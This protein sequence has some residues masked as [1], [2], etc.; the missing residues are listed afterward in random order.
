MASESAVF[1]YYH[2][3]HL[4]LPREA[5]NITCKWWVILVLL[6]QFSYFFYALW[7]TE[8]MVFVDAEINGLIVSIS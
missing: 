5:A 7:H 4:T 8:V 2:G 6:L 1:P 3:Y